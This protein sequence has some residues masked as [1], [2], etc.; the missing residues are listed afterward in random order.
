MRKTIFDFDFARQGAELFSMIGLDTNT[1]EEKDR[2]VCVAKRVKTRQEHKVSS[3]VGEGDTLIK[4]RRWTPSSMKQ[5]S[6]TFHQTEYRK[7]FEEFILKMIRD[8]SRDI[9][10]K[11][12]NNSESQVLQQKRSYTLLLLEQN[13]PEFSFVELFI[14]ECPFLKNVHL[15]PKGISSFEVDSGEYKYAYVWVYIYLNYVRFHKDIDL[16]MRWIRAVNEDKSKVSDKCLD[17]ALY[18][19]HAY[20][21][22]ASK[23]MLKERSEFAQ[24]MMDLRKWV[25]ATAPT[26]GLSK[27]I[28]SQLC[29]YLLN[30]EWVR[31]NA[32][33]WLP[34]D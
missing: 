10:G 20:T 24:I 15:N 14:E 32:T 4:I 23:I 19:I 2:N 22:V 30:E 7:I 31:E 27:N 13:A 18:F 6:A 26:N 8:W 25:E 5:W 17:L 11:A 9:P 21:L 34:D 16:L 33:L 28:K 3:N 1:T 12:T 29:R